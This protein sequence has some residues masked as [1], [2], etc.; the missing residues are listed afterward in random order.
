MSHNYIKEKRKSERGQTLIQRIFIQILISTSRPD[1]QKSIF[2]SVMLALLR[3]VLDPFNYHQFLSAQSVNADLSACSISV[4]FFFYTILF[5]SAY[6]LILTLT[7]ITSSL[8]FL[9]TSGKTQS[10]ISTTYPRYLYS[11]LVFR[12]KRLPSSYSTFAIVDYFLYFC[13]RLI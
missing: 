13:E 11:I 2:L 9:L 1:F 10:L 7:F 3:S 8:F 12:L 6:L 4:P 5:S